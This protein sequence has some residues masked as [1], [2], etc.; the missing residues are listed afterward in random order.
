MDIE[1]YIASGILELYVAGELSEE[2]NLEVQH[3]ALQYPEIQQ[4]IEEIEAAIL[5][6]TQS[7]SPGLSNES[8]ENIK[9]EIGQVIPF[10]P[11]ASSP[12]KPWVSYLGWAASLLFAAGALWM[13]M[14]NTEL[15]SVIEVVTN[16]KQSL[17]EQII[18][19]RND[20][21]NSEELL[22][23][24]R[25]QSVE[26]V[27]LGGQT[28]SPDS[29][30]KVYWNRNTKRLF[31]D[32]QGLPEPPEGYT[33][34][35][36]SLKLNPLTPT[37]IGLLDGIA[38]SETKVFELENPNSSEAFGITLEPEGGSESPTLEQLYTLGTVGP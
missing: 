13:Y 11:S 21:T 19:V 32:T 17:E 24:L 34:Q 31:V 33:Y 1:K 2:Q 29:Y 20:K 16:E 25:E 5:E 30:A 12:R 14:Q 6:L 3:Y 22:R 8:F 26:V 9:K 18:E 15:K 38:E 23:S 36:W 10:V 37:S 28:V 27:A 35:V 4:E 7:V